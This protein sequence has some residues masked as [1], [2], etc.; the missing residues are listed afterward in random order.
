ML[1]RGLILALLARCGAGLVAGQP[2]TQKIGGI[3]YEFQKMSE[4]GSTGTYSDMMLA[5][6]HGAGMRPV[7]DLPDTVTATMAERCIAI[8]QTKP[9]GSISLA[10][11]RDAI[12]RFPAGWSMVKDHFAMLCHYR[13][14]ANS[15]QAVCETTLGSPSGL[16]T[17]VTSG[18]PGFM[19]GRVLEFEAR[20]GVAGARSAKFSG[21]RPPVF[22]MTASTID[23]SGATSSGSPQLV[24]K[25]GVACV[26][27]DNDAKYYEW[28]FLNIGPAAMPVLT[29]DITFFATAARNYGWLLGDEDG[30]CDRTV[31]V[32]DGR[33][34]AGKTGGS[35]L[36]GNW[37]APAVNWGQWNRMTVH[38]NQNTKTAF[39]VVNG[40]KGNVVTGLNQGEGYG[41][42]RLG[43]AWGGHDSNVCVSGFRVYDR[44]P[45]AA[46][47]AAGALTGPPGNLGGA[48]PLAVSD[49]ASGGGTSCAD[50]KSKDP[51]AADGLFTITP[52]GM[53]P[54]QVPL[55]TD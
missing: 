18:Q 45:T 20:L 8:P 43:S 17:L 19:C 10:T 1:A 40:V 23:A 41:R 27:L 12:R 54:L 53:A 2:F 48:A 7:C 37:G 51:S 13:A 24:Q 47:I 16:K 46:E 4:T 32:N 34:G 21:A 3:T 39:A 33:A 35:C 50:I 22:E 30:G 49:A 28:S 55:A 15:G 6:C 14:G 31:L 25:D 42:L 26:E 5:V 11:G 44:A 29:L 9:F 52:S 36:S 38:W